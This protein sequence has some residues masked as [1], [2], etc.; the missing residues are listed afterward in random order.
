[1]KFEF[2][3]EKVN[4]QMLFRIVS[5]LKNLFINTAVTHLD[6]FFDFFFLTKSS[7]AGN[8]F[9]YS[10]NVSFYDRKTSF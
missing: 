3:K 5:K 6:N 2:S 4:I 9:F 8:K 1:M 7:V 10:E